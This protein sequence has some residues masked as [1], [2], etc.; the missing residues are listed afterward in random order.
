MG[1]HTK[2]VD[3]DGTDRQD[4]RDPEEAEPSD[5][6]GC[7]D[8]G[9]EEEGAVGRMAVL[10]EGEAAGRGAD[11]LQDVLL[12]MGELWEMLPWGSVAGTPEV[13]AT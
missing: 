10:L 1:G 12:G 7:L 3:A 2:A 8:S 13:L 9:G 11:L 4:L 6:G 5:D